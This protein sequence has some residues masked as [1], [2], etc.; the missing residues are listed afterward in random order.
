MTYVAGGKYVGEFKANEF[1]GRG[2][3]MKADGVAYVGGFRAGAGVNGTVKW[4]PDR[5]TAWKLVTPKGGTQAFELISLSEARK[6]TAKFGQS[7][8]PLPDA[9]LP[10]A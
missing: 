1:D 10:R 6:L 3:N 7:V 8:P 5:Q 2:T 4:S 9:E